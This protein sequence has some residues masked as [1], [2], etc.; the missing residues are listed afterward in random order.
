MVSGQ[1]ESWP[2]AGV[3]RGFDSSFSKLMFNLN[4]FLSQ[5]PPRQTFLKKRGRM[6]FVFPFWVTGTW[7]VSGASTINTSFAPASKKLFCFIPSWD[8]A[9][10][11]TS[12]PHRPPH[13]VCRPAPPIPSP[14]VDE[15]V[16][17]KTRSKFESISRANLFT[18]EVGPCISPRPRFCIHNRE[19]SE[20]VQD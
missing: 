16:F 6:E 19:I 18:I 20:E 15:R 11:C 1:W 4:Y 5:H 8:A 7:D 2:G 13:R 3:R 10:P 14:T 12:P 9:F 17:F